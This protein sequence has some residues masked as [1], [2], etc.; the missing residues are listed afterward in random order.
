MLRPQLVI[1]NIAIDQLRPILAETV[2]RLDPTA[3]WAGD[4]LA[5]PGLGVEL[6]VD[7]HATMRNVSLV[8]L[9][10]HQD[11]AGWR[12]LERELSAALAQVEVRRDPRGYGLLSTGTLMLAGLAVVIARDP[13][14]IAHA[15]FDMLQW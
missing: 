15:L 9:G 12:R 2:E 10:P 4:S 8:S 14:G 6:H 1:Y 5:L 7:N 13:Q 3:R 11:Y